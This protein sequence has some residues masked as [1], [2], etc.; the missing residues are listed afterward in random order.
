MRYKL[1]DDAQCDVEN[2]FK[3]VRS[4]NKNYESPHWW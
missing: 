2:F 1:F 4:I 3:N